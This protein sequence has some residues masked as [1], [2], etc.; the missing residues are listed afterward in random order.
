MQYDE[1]Y[2][3]NLLKINNDKTTS[4][5]EQEEEE[6]EKR[7]EEVVKKTKSLYD[8]YFSNL[9]NKKSKKIKKP[10]NQEQEDYVQN[11]SVKVKNVNVVKDTPVYLSDFLMNKW[12][13][14]SP[15]D[16]KL[17]YVDYVGKSFGI[18]PYKT[19]LDQLDTTK[20]AQSMAT[21]EGYYNEIPE[22]E[23]GTRA[24]RNNNPGNL[25]YYE[26]YTGPDGILNKAIDTD[27]E[28]AIFKNP[29]D[30]F[31]AMH[32]QIELDKQR[33][34][35]KYK[36][37]NMSSQS[38]E[39]LIPSYTDLQS[40][41]GINQQREDRFNKYPGLGTEIPSPL[42]EYAELPVDMPFDEVGN[43]EIPFYGYE[44]NSEKQKDEKLILLDGNGE[45]VTDE[46][47][48]K[49]FFTQPEPDEFGM[50]PPSFKPVL[51]NQGYRAANLESK[52][53][54]LTTK[55]KDDIIKYEQQV[56]EQDTGIH[57]QIVEAYEKADGNKQA[58]MFNE[59]A[60]HVGYRMAGIASLGISRSFMNKP[61]IT[62]ILDGNL[63]GVEEVDMPTDK[64]RQGR[65][66]RLARALN[67]VGG[68]VE[69]IAHLQAFMFGTTVGLTKLG[70]NTP[71]LAN[72]ISFM[73]AGAFSRATDTNNTE[74]MTAAKWFSYTAADGIMGYAFRPLQNIGGPLLATE[75]GYIKVFSKLLAQSGVLT[76]GMTGTQFGAKVV[77]SINDN[78]NQTFKEAV[79][80]AAGN[81][82]FKLE[83]LLYNMTFMTVMNA[84]SNHKRFYKGDALPKTTA[85]VKGFRAKWSGPVSTK[86]FVGQAEQKAWFNS[87]SGAEKA[88]IYNKQMIAAKSIADKWFMR[89]QTTI[90]PKTGKEIQSK[91]Y[92]RYNKPTTVND[93]QSILNNVEKE[94][95]NFIRKPKAQSTP[96]TSSTNVRET[97]A[98]PSLGI[99]TPIVQKK[100]LAIAESPKRVLERLGQTKLYR[101]NLLDQIGARDYKVEVLDSNI[102]A[103]VTPQAVSKYKR[104]SLKELNAQK[105]QLKILKKQVQLNVN[106]NVE[107][108]KQDL[109][110]INKLAFNVENQIRGLKGLKPNANPADIRKMK[111]DALQAPVK[112]AEALTTPITPIVKTKA[113]TKSVTKT[114]GKTKADEKP[115]IP[116]LRGIAKT[117]SFD[118]TEGLKAGLKNNKT[119]D[120]LILNRDAIQ[121]KV[122]QKLAKELGVKPVSRAKDDIMRAI[123]KELQKKA[124]KPIG[125][126]ESKLNNLNQ[127]QNILA[128]EKLQKQ[129]D[130][131]DLMELAQKKGVKVTPSTTK[132]DALSALFNKMHKGRTIA[133]KVEEQASIVR[134][135]QRG[136]YKKAEEQGLIRTLNANKKA[137]ET[138]IDLDGKKLTATK[139]KDYEISVIATENLLKHK[140]INESKNTALEDSAKAAAERLGGLEVGFLGMTP[141]NF[142]IV[143]RDLKKGAKRFADIVDPNYTLRQ[144]IDD[145]GTVGAQF[146][147]NG[148]N[149]VKDFSKVMTQTFGQSV[150]A[151][152]KKIWKK[153][154]QIVK[155]IATKGI[156]WLKDP[157]IGL[158]IELVGKSGKK[159]SKS[160]KANLQARI[161]S[162]KLKSDDYDIIA[163]NLSNKNILTGKEK[164]PQYP[165]ISELSRYLTD[166]T[167]GI[168]KELGIDLKQD[169]PFNN[170]IIARIL[171]AEIKMENKNTWNAGGWYS[172]KMKDAIKVSE[173]LYP[174]MKNP[175]KNT[176]FRVVLSITS[177]GQGVPS[178][179]RIAYQQFE[180]YLKTG[181]MNSKFG[182]GMTEKQKEQ[183]GAGKEMPA[184]RKS[185]ELYNKLADMVGEEKLHRFLNTKMTAKQLSDSKIKNVAGE[186]ASTEVYGS[187][188]FGPKVGGAFFQNVSGNLEP[189]TMDLHF[190]RNIKRITGQLLPK[191]V[192]GDAKQGYEARTGFRDYSKHLKTFKSLIVKNR[193]VRNEYG[194]TPA[195]YKD[196]KAMIDI[197]AKI[198]KADSSYKKE[199][200]IP[201]KKDPSKMVEGRFPFKVAA[202][203]LDE[204]VN[205]PS[206]APGS[207][208][209]RKRFREIMDYTVKFSE[210]TSIADAQAKLW[211]PQKRFYGKFGIKGESIN[212]TDYRN[213]AIKLAK[214]RGFDSARIERILG[215][216]Q[217][218]VVGKSSS[219]INERPRPL[220]ENEL[221]KIFKRYGGLEAGFLGIT[222]QNVKI[223]RD[224]LIETG[225]FTYKNLNKGTQKAGEKLGINVNNFKKMFNDYANNPKNVPA[226][227]K[228]FFKKVWNQMKGWWKNNRDAI[229]TNPV[230]EYLL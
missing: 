162:E 72:T 20:L 90:D 78:P 113:P 168:Q 144:K 180:H 29:E 224:V 91:T 146:I 41:E 181:K 30:G 229:M 111:R 24:Q 12:A 150:K 136:G 115:I 107:G 169:T 223:V 189:L 183:L 208:A 38:L 201:S 199:T 149:N 126:L 100:P 94:F 139:R 48:L 73:S 217:R 164:A 213:E 157:K 44:Y 92:I 167:R 188:I 83:N 17:A 61:I 116:I 52:N 171:S 172:Q 8:D 39:G 202:Q 177:N 14:T 31:D 87:L 23:E 174:E 59:V 142:K 35:E 63:T 60:K 185:F 36:L 186:L 159:L 68:F 118:T 227:L 225:K 104:D 46:K 216:Q 11:D 95:G 219:K 88:K 74:K 140:K 43:A 155:D 133:P 103:L 77:N 158:G 114:Y 205:K 58:M 161:K 134:E 200:M 33:A 106:K 124:S 187:I 6:E 70:L 51:E 1:N 197:A 207:G 13:N 21:F 64:T 18:D 131:Y 67:G 196:D 228:V 218:G 109:D 132:T 137:L 79:I 128:S 230:V 214:E 122:V 130:V 176:A 47:I 54:L 145:A 160:Q 98:T 147:I 81:D 211:F 173:A 195:V 9:V 56:L 112:D 212:E 119:S 135:K 184:M 55:E 96:K 148:F 32:R 40:L 62:K 175:I 221:Q 105:S 49:Q 82:E 143:G 71:G 65:D 3:S 123:E 198:H 194:I 85:L 190:T 191:A 16:E 121:Y 84:L 99:G 34:A 4:N 163:N 129:V 204:R 192:K 156:N 215:K 138:G 154:Q 209:E 42:L 75:G 220:K 50:F 127:F 2:F 101:Q 120:A 97:K 7:K 226:K 102:D 80:D 179:M 86:N 25:A 27:G 69:A 89:T 53:I 141:Q 19:R 210:E 152:M 206:E 125:A 182:I 26:E 10:I 110:D 93:A 153:A 45:V 117:K 66:L 203:R 151:F 222:P 57:S 178:N 37:D 76:A 22:G 193:K 15:E 28:F 165:N 170:Q 166:R 5:L 108:A